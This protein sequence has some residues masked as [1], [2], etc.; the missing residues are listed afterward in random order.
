[1][2]EISVGKSL[3]VV[4]KF[5]RSDIGPGGGEDFQLPGDLEAG[6]INGIPCEPALCIGS[7]R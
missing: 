3:L 5:T 4:S 1:M 2:K 6:P 7:R